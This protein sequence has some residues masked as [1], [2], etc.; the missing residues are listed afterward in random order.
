MR[1]GNRIRAA[2]THLPRRAL[3]SKRPNHGFA[4]RTSRPRE[5]RF[6]HLFCGLLAVKSDD[7]VRH[8]QRLY[9]LIKKGFILCGFS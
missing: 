1:R 2:V 8:L 5:Q 4:K 9:Y 7:L 6:Q 3:P